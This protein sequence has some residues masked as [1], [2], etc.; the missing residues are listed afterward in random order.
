MSASSLKRKMKAYLKR[1][2]RGM[3][4]SPSEFEFDA[5]AAIYWFASDHHGGQFSELYEI[6][7]ASP[8]SPGPSVRSAK[9]ESETASFM[10]DA[11]VGKFAPSGSLGQAT[12]LQA[13]G[14]PS[15]RTPARRLEARLYKDDVGW[16]A[17]VMGP[18]QEFSWRTLSTK[19]KE[20]A[21]A[22]V[23]EANRVLAVGG[24]PG[25]LGRIL[26]R[27]R[28]CPAGMEVQS[29]AFRIRDGWTVP[30]AKAWAKNHGFR[31]G[32]ADVTKNY[33]R[34]RQAPPSRFSRVRWGRPFA[35]GIVPL[36]GCPK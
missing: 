24:F 16:F 28:R 5:E 27:I 21:Q 1:E 10:Y 29:I 31:Y 15:R 2:T 19:N 23:E 34:L 33:I 11:L 3:W 20:R 26:G 25:A 9:D 4:D 6:L 30:D 8:Y 12:W 7:S 36:Y 13:G 17:G 18:D 32:K 35:R 14:R 22:W